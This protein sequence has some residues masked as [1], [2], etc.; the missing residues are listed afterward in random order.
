MQH[1]ESLSNLTKALAQFQSEVENPKLSRE[2]P[3]FKSKF[4]PLSEVLNTV[5]PFLT[6]HGL[7]V[8]QNVSSDEQFNVVVITTVFHSSGEFIESDPL[9]IPAGRGGKPAD[10]Q[11]I[12]G[13]ASY[14]KR[15]QIQACLGI[16]ADEDDDGEALSNRGYQAKPKIETLNTPSQAQLAAKYQLVMGSR[17]GFE[18]YCK[19]LYEQGK[20]DA[21]ILSA[22]DR[23]IGMKKEK[24]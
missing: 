20:D 6:K 14:G 18:E 2:N 16:T 1:S 10:A 12:G 24:K 15:Y 17:N 19:K 11:G 8:Y 7:S 22:L 21:Y 9:K 5:R 23:A 3:H 13:A 4:A